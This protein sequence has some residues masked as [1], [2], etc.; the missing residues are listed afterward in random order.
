MAGEDRTEKATPKHRQEARKRGDVAR[1]QDLSGALV[2]IAGI[3]T[4]ALLG[5]HIAN[6]FGGFMRAL[7]ADGA[8]PQAAFT[9]AGMKGLFD[10]AA[11]TVALT[12]G[13]I[14]GACFV[15]GL[16]GGLAQI[17]RPYPQAPKFD[18]KHIAPLSNAKN[19]FGPNAFFET[20]KAVT[21]VAAV[22]AVAAI[23]LVPD[24]TGLAAKVG[25]EPLTLGTLSGST[26]LSV[27][28]RAGFAYLLIGLVDYG[29]RRRKHER[30]LRM[31]KQE[32]KEE[33]RQHAVSNE[34]KQ[35]LRRRQMQ[36]AKARM[37]AAVPTADVIVTNPTHYAVALK[38]DGS[39]PAPELVAKGQD[40]IAA[41]IRK[42]AAEHDVPIVPD[43]PLA[44]A[45][46]SSCEIG[47]VI[48]AEL[49]LAVARVLAFVYKLAGRKRA[50]ARAA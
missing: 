20:G 39:K 27:A 19:I 1:S 3:M 11:S 12:V 10:D 48:P 50:A 2:L 17:G 26:A 47:Q 24:V 43:P 46:H 34:V 4:I 36:A 31:T 23:T 5:S 7:I 16:L 35:A 40:L 32:V 15:A 25:I 38:Y 8:N 41:Q 9:A 21:K 22:G 42:V 44:R 45:I 18:F 37:M 13:P 6:S 28:E 30:S 49:Y 33:A 29:W 14:A